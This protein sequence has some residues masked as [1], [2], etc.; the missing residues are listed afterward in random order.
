[1]CM[2]IARNRRPELMA[3]IAPLGEFVSLY[4]DGTGPRASTSGRST[5]S[6]CTGSSS[7]HA[8]SLAASPCASVEP[9]FRQA[10]S[11]YPQLSMSTRYL[12]SGI[13][14]FEHGRYLK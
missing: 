4:E 14:D 13:E 2:P 6:R 9:T 3:M 8:C 11:A 1:M 7:R 5:S 12:I 10:F